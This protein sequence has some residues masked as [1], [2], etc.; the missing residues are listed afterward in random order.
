LVDLFYNS[1]DLSKIIKFTMQTLIDLSHQYK[2]NMQVVVAWGDM[3]AAQHV[4][5]IMYLRYLESARIQYMEDIQFGFGQNEV[6]IILAEV[7]VKYKIP[8]TFPDTLWVGTKTIIESI[9]ESSLWT[10]QVIFSQVHQKITTIS[11]ARL[12]CYNY[13][14][15]KKIVWPD[16]V[17]RQILEFEG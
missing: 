9:E 16:D 13:A 15:L 3:D 4:N 1:L 11:T 7:N 14:Q 5:N 10:E 6:G 8:V 2:S 17:K 12:V